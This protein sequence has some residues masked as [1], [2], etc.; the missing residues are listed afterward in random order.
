[1]NRIY[2]WKAAPGNRSLIVTDDLHRKFRLTFTGICVDLLWQNRLEFEP[3]APSRLSCLAP[4]DRI[5]TRDIEGRI[6]GT[7]PIARIETYTPEME[8]ADTQSR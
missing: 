2:G 8:K 5:T 4:G 6:G 3:F 1:M 7:C